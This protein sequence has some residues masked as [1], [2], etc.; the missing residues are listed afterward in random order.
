MAKRKR[1][2]PVAAFTT[3]TGPAAA[4]RAPIADVARDAA[5]SAA[6]YD[7]VGEMERARAEGRLLLS[8]ALDDIESGH[9]LRDRLAASVQDDEMIALIASIRARGQQVPIEV[10]DLGEGQH[11]RYG[12]ISGW[13][14]L[15]AIQA[16]R[17]ETGEPR[18]DVIQAV[19]RR[20]D[21]AA[22]AYVAMVEENE[23]RVGLS[24]YERA[25]VA[26]R[27]AEAGVFDDIASAIAALFASASKAKR[28]KIGSFVRIY[29]ELDAVLRWPAALPERL[30]LKLAQTLALGQGAAVRD[31]LNAGKPEDAAA[32][33]AVLA[34]ALA[35]A[36]AP[37]APHAPQIAP[38]IT[39]KRKGQALT[40]SGPGITPELEAALTEWLQARK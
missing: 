5:A 1:L 31:A 36:A 8:L 10:S 40:L 14:R 2:N 22:D 33:Q 38:G 12:L 19:L 28:S 9:L 21:G 6:L 24:Y 3:Q 20:P 37:R 16:L 17:A 13:R 27:S 35:P 34:K 11:P 26:A 39:L 25:R 7:L 32:E 18:F 29:Q 30:G 15:A 4:T 23:I